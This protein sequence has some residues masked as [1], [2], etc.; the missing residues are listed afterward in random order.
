MRIIDCFK[1]QR[2]RKYRD[3]PEIAETIKKY[4]R[5][6]VNASKE[7]SNSTP[8]RPACTNVWGL[9]NFQPE[10]SPG[11]DDTSIEDAKKVLIYQGKLTATRDQGKVDFY[12]D[13]TFADRR[14]AI[15]K[16]GATAKS[17]I[18]QYPDL[19]SEEGVSY[20]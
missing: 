1:N 15:I 12:M 9:V 11:E 10:R 2:K 19:A 16:E 14:A 20:Q 18:E 7:A 5:N 4:K 17:L 3:V 13:R 8:P 6:G